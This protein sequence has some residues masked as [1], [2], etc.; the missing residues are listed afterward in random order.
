MTQPQFAILRIQKLKTL[1]TIK[2]SLKHSFREQET[3]N[4]DKSLQGENTHIGA[5]SSDQA[6]LK[7]QNLLPEKR[8]KD[9]VLCVEYLI[10]ASPE[11]MNSK[12]RKEQD[13]YFNDSLE[14][15]IERHGAKHVVYSGIHRDEKTPHMYAYIIPIDETSK[16]LNAKKW[17]GELK[18]L[19]QMQTDFALRVGKKHNLERGIEGSKA[20]HQK[21]K[22]FYALLEQEQEI[23]CIT[24]QELKRQKLEGETLTEKI[25]GVKE[26][27]LGVVLRLNKKIEDHVR[28][29]AEKAAISAQETKRRKELQITALHLQKSLATHREL[30]NGLSEQQVKQLLEA[31]QKLK[32]ENRFAREA[33]RQEKLAQKKS[34]K[35]KI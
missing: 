30:L 35:R 19:N 32:D 9:A 5:T 3:P 7:V 14:W 13:A 12:T 33:L 20:R 26:T 28:P 24:E 15:L 6:M 8:R 29:L 23:P 22:R 21:V 31:S 10:T 34:L 11:I 18:A 1:A 27:D 25:L 16:R 2:R 17:F 4:A